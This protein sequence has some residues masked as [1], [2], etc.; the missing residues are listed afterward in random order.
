MSVYATVDLHGVNLLAYE[1]PQW[2]D[3][4][5]AHGVRLHVVEEEPDSRAQCTGTRRSQADPLQF[6]TLDV[7]VPGSV[8]I[9]VRLVEPIYDTAAALAEDPSVAHLCAQKPLPSAKSCSS[10]HEKVKLYEDSSLYDK[11]ELSL[12]WSN[13]P[14]KDT[15]AE[16]CMS[17]RSS[18]WTPAVHDTLNAS[19]TQHEFERALRELELAGDDE[20]DE[21][22]RCLPSNADCVGPLDVGMWGA[23]ADG[24]SIVPC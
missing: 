15:L 7:C 22:T 24:R 18:L 13:R 16:M 23:L 20:E 10:G 5:E 12:W 1:F 14:R 8:T 9:E 3:T 19:D 6:Q 11:V 4:C 17:R 2:H 21:L